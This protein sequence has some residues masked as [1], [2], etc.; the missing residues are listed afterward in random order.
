MPLFPVDKAQLRPQFATYR[1]TSEDGLTQRCHELPVRAATQGNT[2]ALGY[3]ELKARA[4]HGALVPL[5][6]SA[7]FAY[8]DIEGW[9]TLASIEPPA[10]ERVYHVGA[11]ATLCVADERTLVVC[12]GAVVAHVA[13]DPTSMRAQET[14][15]YTAPDVPLQ[16]D[17]HAM[18]W[19]IAVASGADILLER[20]RRKAQTGVTPGLGAPSGTR[21]AQ[22]QTYFDVAMLR[23][24][25]LVWHVVTDEP[26]AFASLGDTSVLGAE[27]PLGPPATSVQPVTPPARD[28]PPYT[29]SQTE[30]T[31]TVALALP[32]SLTKHDIRVHFSPKAL[33]VSLAMQP[34]KI[35][36]L[37][38]TTEPHSTTEDALRQGT[39]ESRVLWD[40]I[41][42]G[43]SLWTWENVQTRTGSETHVTGLLT[44]HLAKAHEGTRWPQVLEGDDIAETLDPSE[45]LMMLE[46]LEKY[47]EGPGSS[48]LLNDGLEEEDALAGTR[49]V[50]SEVHADGSIR[51]AEPSDAG[52]LLARAAPS[53]VA[54]SHLLFKYDVDGIIYAPPATPTLA[55]W[56]PE[57]VVPAISYVLAS[58]RDAHPVYF[59]KVPGA[60]ASNVFAF[61]PRQSSSRSGLGHN[62]FVYYTP[63]GSN[64]GVSRV[65]RLAD[66]VQGAGA[67]LGVG[68]S[69]DA[70]LVCLFESMLLVIDHALFT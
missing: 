1:L 31:V 17:E 8:M 18:P 65:F 69:P 28:L 16:G 13:I 20:A 9:V 51:P 52:V 23:T 38:A 34:A 67:L 24:G 32:A 46:G 54:T 59:Y 33:S 37:D 10:F 53:N 44:L 68:V 61:E 57:E 45:M 63:P 3:K 15:R 35:T 42:V 66:H 50:L 27:T 7:L 25:Q 60:A 2:A 56:T 48:S 55:P 43:E 4:M 70:R 11:F 12:D 47:T 30:D 5:P 6:A 39:Y 14:A 62:A 19:R 26:V 21:H 49:F 64:D 58:K 29:W 22:T 40:Q 36:E 41:N